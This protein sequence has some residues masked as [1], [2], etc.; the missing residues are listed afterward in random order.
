MPFIAAGGW[1]YSLNPQRIDSTALIYDPSPI[2]SSIVR[3]YSET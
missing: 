2:L 3:E 1:K